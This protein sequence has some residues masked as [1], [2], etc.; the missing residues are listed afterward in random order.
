MGLVID[1]YI[2]YFLIFPPIPHFT[3]QC[4]DPYLVFPRSA[5][6]PWPLQATVISSYDKFD[7]LNSTVDLKLWILSKHPMLNH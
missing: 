1:C 2:Y 4:Y 7:I 6:P 3:S 5:S